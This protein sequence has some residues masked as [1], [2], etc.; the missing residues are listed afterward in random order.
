MG[1][2]YIIINSLYYLETPLMFAAI[3]LISL[4]GITFYGVIVLIENKFKKGNCHK[5]E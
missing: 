1:L 5:E 2:G 4:W 3:I